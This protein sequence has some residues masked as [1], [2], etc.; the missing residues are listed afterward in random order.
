MA[1]GLLQ[2]VSYGSQ[3]LFL[4]GT[5]QITFF[6]VVYRRHT[7]F[8][9]ESVVVPFDDKVSFGETSNVIIPRNGDLFHKMYL[10]ITIPEVSIPRQIDADDITAARQALT[11]ALNNYYIVVNF[12]NVNT[13]AYRIAYD[14]FIAANLT[15]GAPMIDNI[16]SVFQAA[17][18][19]IIQK[20]QNL[21]DNTPTNIIKYSQISLESYADKFKLSGETDKQI[22]M[23]GYNRGIDN[24]ILIQKFFFDLVTLAK[25]TLADVSNTNYKFAWVKRLGHV[26]IDYVEVNIGGITIDKHYGDWLNVWYELTGNRHME[27]TYFKMIGN[28]PELTTYDRNI[29]AKRLLKIPLQFWFCRNNGLVFP[30]LAVEYHEVN[31]AVKFKNFNDCA[32]VEEDDNNQTVDLNEYAENSKIDI[33]AQLLVDYVF[34]DGPERKRFAQSSHEYLFEQVQLDY[35]ENI[36]TDNIEFALNL[37]HPCKEII[38]T[39]QRS[40]YT[41][42][43]N[44]HTETHNDL[45]SSLSSGY[46]N[47]LLTASLDLDSYNR[48][49]ESDYK[50][51]NYLQ[52][53]ICHKN[54]PADGINVYSF[55]YYPEEHQPSGTCNMSRIPR[56]TMHL[57]FDKTVFENDETLNIRFYATNYNILRFISG[58]AGLS[59]I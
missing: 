2:L 47:P 53:Y 51:F 56:V 23:N 41:K 32:F 39:A 27:D 9:I 16:I 50:Y 35:F 42:N 55:S 34:L 44:G 11:T 48:I 43:D 40:S 52:P 1:G 33:N 20:F 22:I 21:L 12:M 59:F 18:P 30:L 14:D 37:N 3:D 4:T 17:D 28:V 46:G 24:S 19:L 26:I 15:T 36:N 7:N 6:K 13:K 54:T 10:E 31:I 8:A 5:P 58:L 49:A 57:K 29:K 45:Y 38:W 25:N